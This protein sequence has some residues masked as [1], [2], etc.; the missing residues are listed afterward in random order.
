MPFGPYWAP[1]DLNQS[2]LICFYVAR[3]LNK[4]LFFNALVKN[5]IIWEK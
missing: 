5:E 3:C 4:V 2:Q 1:H